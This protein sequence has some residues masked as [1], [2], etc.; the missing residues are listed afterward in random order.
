MDVYV[1]V[2]KYEWV[3][4]FLYDMVEVRIEFNVVMI[5]LLFVVCVWVWCL[6]KVRDVFYEVKVW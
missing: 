5:C 4:E 2:G 1:S 3:W 6:E